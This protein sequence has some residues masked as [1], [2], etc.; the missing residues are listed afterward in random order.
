MLVLSRKRM[1]RIQIGD[2]VVVTVL[3]IRCNSVRIGIEAPEHVSVFRT[4]LLGLEP[5]KSGRI[6]RAAAAPPVASMD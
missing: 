5:R 6:A 1:E 2:G 3:A 4:E